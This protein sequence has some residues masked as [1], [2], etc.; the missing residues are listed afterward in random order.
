MGNKANAT[1]FVIIKECETIKMNTLSK[2]I[3]VLSYQGSYI[4]LS[5]HMGKFFY[6]DITF[7]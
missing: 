3:N 2:I 4:L 6:A 5:F 1:Y 7:T